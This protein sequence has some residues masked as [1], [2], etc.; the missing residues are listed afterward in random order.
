VI[1]LT[2]M[3]LWHGK[4]PIAKANEY[5]KFLIERAVP[6]Y[7]SVD[8]LIKPCFTRREEEEVAHF[9]LV[10]IWDSM[11]SIKKF[12]GEN[13]ELEKYCPEDNDFL[14]EKE[15]YVQHYKVFYEK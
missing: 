9:L 8:G 14:L 11:E 13:P 4:A 12:T 10:T 6:D 3:R 15:K 1:F 2:I 5:E 7:G